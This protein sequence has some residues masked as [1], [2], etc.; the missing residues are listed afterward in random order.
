MSDTSQDLTVL[1][2][3]DLEKAREEAAKIDVRN[4]QAV[5]QFGVGA[6]QKIAGFADSVLA[7]I[8]NKDAG[9]AGNILASLLDRI[10][11]LDVDSLSRNKSFLERIPGVGSLVGSIRK[12]ITRYEKVSGQIERIVL[13]LETAQRNLLKDIV[14]LDELYTKNQEYLKDLDIL[15]AAGNLKIEELRNTVL[16]ELKAKAESTR[17]PADAQRFQDLSSLVDRFEKKLHDL[18]L[19][20]MVSL[21]MAPQIRLIQNNNQ[22][23]V[24]KIQSSILTTLPLWKNQVVLAISLFRQKKALELQKEVSQATNELLK[25][26]A[27]LLKEGS[28][29]VAEESERGIVELETLKQVNEDLIT[30]LEETLRIQKEGREKRARAE[31]ELVQ[32]ENQLKE[33]LLAGSK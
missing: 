6:Q 8:R 2:P 24:E 25:R 1:E 15:L 18:K 23:L 13:E 22:V 16:P 14:L 10:K 7:E 19:S 20:R 12:F 17:D 26:N 21:Q 28:L 27:A 9:E 11:E 31:Q 29:G 32:L 5:L 3:R 4:S 33:R 30:T